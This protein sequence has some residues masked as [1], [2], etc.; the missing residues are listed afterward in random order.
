MKSFD[1]ATVFQAAW[2][3]SAENAVTWLPTSPMHIMFSV[4]KEWTNNYGLSCG[5][6]FV[7]MT[8]SL[9]SLLYQNVDLL[10]PCCDQRRCMVM[11]PCLKCMPSPPFVCNNRRVEEHLLC[12]CTVWDFGPIS[13]YG[14]SLHQRLLAKE[15]TFWFL[16]SSRLNMALVRCFGFSFDQL[17]CHPF[18]NRVAALALNDTQNPFIIANL[19]WI[20]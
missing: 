7:L 20:R 3:Q 1:N 18:F 2:T 8:P 14:S 11:C 10:Q 19:C 15:K 5:V 6:V 16:S 13:S 12:R 17:L 4:N 9:L